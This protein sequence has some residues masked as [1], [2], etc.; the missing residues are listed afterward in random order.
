MQGPHSPA[1]APG[2]PLIRGTVM[3]CSLVADIAGHQVLLNQQR[4]QD[5]GL[6]VMTAG[7]PEHDLKLDS[8]LSD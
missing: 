1:R 5:G 2:S 8:K 4:V 6:A 3:E 7:F